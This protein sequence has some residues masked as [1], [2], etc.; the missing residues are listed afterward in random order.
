LAGRWHRNR[1]LKSS[2]GKRSLG[3]N[4]PASHH[5]LPNSTALRELAHAVDQALTLPNP[6]TTRD[7]VTYLRIIRDRA[8]VVRQAMRQIIGDRELGDHD[9][10]LM[11]TSLRDEIGQLPDDSHDHQPEPS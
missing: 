3:V 11:V 5:V 9:V 2:T 4:D 10:M 7:E 8:Q 6:A 1:A